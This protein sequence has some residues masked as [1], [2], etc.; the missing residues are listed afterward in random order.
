MGKKISG[1]KVDEEAIKEAKA[2]G[3][4]ISEV[5]RDALYDAIGK[6]KSKKIEYGANGEVI[7]DADLASWMV[8]TRKSFW[9]YAEGQQFA[10]NRNNA[11][12]WLEGR[13]NKDGVCF[14]RDQ[15]EHFLNSLFDDAVEKLR[16]RFTTPAIDLTKEQIETMQN[17][18]YENFLKY[19]KTRKNYMD[20]GTIFDWCEVR[21]KKYGHH[22]TGVKMM[23]LFLLRYL[24]TCK[25][26]G[27]ACDMPIK[28][29]MNYIEVSIPSEKLIE[30][31]G[32]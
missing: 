18:D 1:F 14:T 6:G 4:N 9:K 24:E 17:Q 21:A 16:G 11:S 2:K 7:I 31:G 15:E 19:I 12:I 29:W 32:K 27:K 26:E 20:R 30:E 25:K 23:R 22:L 10:L 13:L 28:E 5:A 8:N 3:I